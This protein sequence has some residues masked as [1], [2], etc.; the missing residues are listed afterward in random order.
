MVNTSGGLTILPELATQD[1]D[2]DQVELI[3]YFKT[4]APVREIGLVTNRNYLKEKIVAA[5]SDEI[6]KVVP[7]KMLQ[8]QERSVVTP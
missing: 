1:F 2:E 4:P 7:P 3:R 8:M 5:L 6:Q